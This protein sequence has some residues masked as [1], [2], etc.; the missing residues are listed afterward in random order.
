[1][2]PITLYGSQLFLLRRKTFPQLLILKFKNNKT[3]FHNPKEKIDDRLVYVVTLST[4]VI[5]HSSVYYP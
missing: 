4:L 2:N 1:M 5:G 3:I